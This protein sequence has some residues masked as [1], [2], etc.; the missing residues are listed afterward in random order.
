MNFDKTKCKVL[1]L[2]QE[3]P[4]YKHRLGEELIKNS[5]AEKGLGIL[6]DQKLDQKLYMSQKCTFA[7]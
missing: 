3:N 4:R 6:M 5:P 2:V 7:A 1:H